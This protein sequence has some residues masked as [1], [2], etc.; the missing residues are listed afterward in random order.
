MTDSLR[1]DLN[2]FLFTPIADDSNGMHLTMLSALARSGVDPWE[3]AAGLR[4][5]SRVDA[6]ERLVL[7]LA[8]VP[9]GPSPG[10]PAATLAARLVD[11]LHAA[12]KAR[13]RPTSPA[14]AAN[15]ADP[16]PLSFATLPKPVKLTIYL[17][18]VLLLMIIGYRALISS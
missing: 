6:T 5:L 1:S 7:L 14:S 9:N 16:P 2:D 15:G 18:G 11:Q 10:D 17:L 8:D 12:P 13:P 3:E 4:A